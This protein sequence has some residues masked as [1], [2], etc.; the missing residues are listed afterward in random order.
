MFWVKDDKW[1][2]CFSQ[3]ITCSPQIFRWSPLDSFM[4]PQGWETLRR[5]RSTGALR[6]VVPKKFGIFQKGIQKKEPPSHVVLCFFPH[7][8]GWFT[9]RFLLK[10]GSTSHE[11]GWT[12]TDL[13][14]LPHNPWLWLHVFSVYFNLRWWSPLANIF[15]EKVPAETIIQSIIS[16]VYWWSNMA[17][18]KVR[19]LVPCFSHVQVLMFF[20]DLPAMFHYRLVF[21]STLSVPADGAGSP[22]RL[23]RTHWCRSERHPCGVPTTAFRQLWKQWVKFRLLLVCQLCLGFT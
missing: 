9:V 3:K 19:H 18:W 23:Y 1:F 15:F 10:K 5:T 17:C 22:T 8:W 13:P 6:A 7:V 4:L 21:R 2:S 12:K 14:P 16:L 11:F 20:F